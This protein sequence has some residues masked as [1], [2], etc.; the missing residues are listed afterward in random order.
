MN[1][2]VPVNASPFVGL[3]AFD[4]GDAGWF[5]GRVREVAALT[6]KLRSARFTAVI[7]PSGCG[8]SSLVRAGVVPLLHA[9]DWRQIIAKPGFA[10]LTR[11]AGALAASVQN[12]QLNEARRFRFDAMLRGSAF[13]LAEIADTLA[14]DSPRLLLVI[15]QFEEL[16]RYG[17]DASGTGRAAMH[18]EA[19]AFVESLL[20]GTAHGEGRLHICI[21]MRSDF[22]GNCAAY[23]GLAE[24][25]SDS[26]FLVPFPLRGQLEE[27]IRRPIEQA[28]GL[29]DEMLVQRL[30]V[31]VE[32]EADQLPLLQHTLRR[33]W[34]SASGTRRKLET[35]GYVA[36][37]R[38][39]GSIEQAAEDVMKR[40]AD[41][42]SEDAITVELVMK[43][44]T[45]LDDRERAARRPQ[46][47]S[48][49]VKLLKGTPGFNAATAEASVDR[50]LSVL[51]AEETSFL[52]TGEGDD[53]EID[54]GHEALMRGWTR[55]SGKNR[56]FKTGWLREDLEDGDRWRGYVRRAQ[57]G[58][59][60][61]IRERKSMLSWLAKRHLGA[62]WAE[63]YGNRWGEIAAFRRRSL[64][65]TAAGSVALLVLLG[66]II[67]VGLTQYFLN[68][69]TRALNE[70]DNVREHARMIASQKNYD[71]ALALFSGTL[72]VYQRAG[73]ASRLVH[74]LVDRGRIYAFLM[75][76]QNLA[77]Q[78]FEQALDIARNQQNIGDEALVHE[79]IAWLHEQFGEPEQA[80][81][82][83]GRALD[84]FK[85][86]GDA[87]SIAHLS[88]WIAT[89]KEIQ[90]EFDGAINLYRQALESY[91]SAGDMIGA[92]RISAS[93][94]RI[95]SWGFLIDVKRRNAFP[96]RGD[97]ITIGRDVPEEGIRNDVGFTDQFVSRRHL[98][99]SREGFHADDVRSRNGTTVN[100]DQLPYGVGAHLQDGDIISLANREVLQFRTQQPLLPSIPQ[101]A[102]A[103]FIDG[104]S[105]SYSYLTQ[106][107][108]SLSLTS[109]GIQIQASDIGSAPIK[110]RRTGKNVELLDASSEWSVIVI[111]KKDDYN[112]AKYPLPTGQW[113]DE[114]HDLP[115]SLAKLSADQK[116]VLQEGPAFQIVTIA[117]D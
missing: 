63:R 89:R 66:I 110:V 10:P 35:Q 57:E 86:V 23:A 79:A 29:I 91:V 56:D 43:A 48:D 20:T 99:I 88:E 64:W 30:L 82:L 108:Y 1:A 81:Q 18:E 67:R 75:K 59:S 77:D 25:V 101:Q 58:P 111:V 62:A 109:G 84:E 107:V 61:S 85:K 78:D 53:P 12:D 102:W 9:D 112:Y 15:D 90:N 103:I 54:I 7:G 68:E 105:K 76:K 40:L 114:L 115:A 93:L 13:G 80:V 65:R 21:T 14:R 4:T 34:E 32:E 71:Q 100:A 116:H 87:P 46:A 51:S 60:L 92:G 94:D 74:A 17:E 41:A 42:H 2:V 28:G 19:R 27:A 95:V 47:R 31:D 38:I 52:Q 33:L 26:Q 6:R 37:G 50:V 44:L 83:Y 45:H 104:S 98:V 96:L 11:L 49:L 3:R 36:V 8:K 69:R 55:T 24:A 117:A 39:R 5:F 113:T 70:A 106:P 22:F 16:F 97:R 73:D 72:S